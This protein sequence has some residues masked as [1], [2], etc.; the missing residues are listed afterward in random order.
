LKYYATQI[1]ENLHETPE[2]Y[3]LALGVPIG[4]TGEMEYGHGETPLEPGSD[5]VVRISREAEELFKPE[6]IASFEG[7]P[8]TIRHPNEFVNSKNWKDLAKGTIKNVRRKGD[9]LVAD[10]QITDDFAISLVKNGMRQLSCGYEAEYIQTGKGTGL[11]KNIVGNHLAL[12]EEGR[13]GDA[14]A[15]NDEKGVFRMNKKV[16]DMMKSLFGKTVDEAVAAEEKAAA[17]AKKAAKKT[18]IDHKAIDNASRDELVAM[19]KDLMEKLAGKDYDGMDEDMPEKKEKPA[20]KKEGED[21]VEL[22]MEERMKALEAAVQKLLEKGSEAGDEEEEEEVIEDEDMPE[23][24][25]EDESSE[26][27]ESEDE[28]PKL[29][30]D[31]KS[32]VEILAPGMAV[33]T[34]DYKRAA[35]KAA[36]KTEDGKKAIETICGGKPTFDSAPQVEM[37]FIATSELLKSSRGSQLARTKKTS[38]FSSA[39]FTDDS[40]MTPEKMNEINAKKYNSK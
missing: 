9:D 31:E 25:S 8:F 35:L 15:I 39:I 19:A 17:K 16:A 38:D 10:I 5:G 24:K 40:V 3:L 6:T 21:E 28:G 14:Y 13:A 33:S 22:S 18:T 4:R 29:T 23:E 30:G 2:G 1:S 32:R 12:V 7:K 27:E 36:Y 26:E 11:Q 20:P 37:L 34:K